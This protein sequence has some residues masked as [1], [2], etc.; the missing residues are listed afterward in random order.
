MSV[1]LGRKRLFD[2]IKIVTTWKI[3]AEIFLGGWGRRAL[4][5]TWHLFPGGFSV[6]LNGAAPALPSDPAPLRPVSLPV[7]LDSVTIT[8][9]KFVSR[10]RFFLLRLICVISGKGS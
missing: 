5:E 2:F 3:A 4:G 7:T 10:S 1:P 8:I 6:T 9:K